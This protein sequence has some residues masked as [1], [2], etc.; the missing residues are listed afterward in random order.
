MKRIIVSLFTVAL[1]LTAVPA[2]AD[3]KPTYPMKGDAF[4]TM[5]DARITKMRSKMEERLTKNKVP[6]AQ[7][8]EARA[9]FSAGVAKVQEATKKATADGTVTADE[10]K[11]VREAAKDLRGGHGGHHRQG[12]H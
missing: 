6:E 3:S 10:A 4:Q 11:T 8:K 7:A 9:K 5:I 1:A 2:F 12:K